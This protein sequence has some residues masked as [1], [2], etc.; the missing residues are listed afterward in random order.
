MLDYKII[1][2]N[3]DFLT[4]KNIISVLFQIIAIIPLILLFI[5]RDYFSIII[6][7]FNM[8]SNFL[9]VFILSDEEYKIPS[10][11]PSNEISGNSLIINQN[12]NI[13]G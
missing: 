3:D 12:G 1:N 9:I 10:I 11:T 4:K 5:F 8:L 13:Y 2:S 7:I 6:I